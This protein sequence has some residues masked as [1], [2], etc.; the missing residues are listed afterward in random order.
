MFLLFSLS[1]I[2]VINSINISSTFEKAFNVDTTSPNC[3]YIESLPIEIDG[4]ADFAIQASSNGWPGS[5]IAGDPY[6]IENLN[7]TSTSTAINLIDISNTKSYFIVN[8]SLLVGGDNGVQLYNV[9]NAKFDNNTIYSN[10]GSGY[11]IMASWDNS[12]YNNTIYD[13]DTGIYLINAHNNCIDNNTIY[14]NNNDG[15]LC[16]NLGSNTISRNIVHNNNL[17]GMRFRDASNNTISDNFIYSNLQNGIYFG[18]SNESKVFNNTIFENANG[19]EFA[20]SGSCEIIDNLIYDNMALGILLTN[21]G[22]TNIS[23]NTFYNQIWYALRIMSGINYNVSLNNFIDNNPGLPPQ[24]IVEVEAFNSDINYNYWND[25]IMPDENLDDIVDDPY[26]IYEDNSYDYYPRTK[27]YIYGKVHIL[28]KPQMY[29]PNNGVISG[30]TKV[31]WG[32]ASDTMGHN[33]EYTL[34]F[35]TNGENWNLIADNILNNSYDWDTTILPDNYTYTIKVVAN[36]SEGFIQEDI[37]DNIFVIGNSLHTISVPEIL[38]PLGGTIIEFPILVEW[39]PSTDSWG[40]PV[41]Y[42]VFWSDDGGLQWDIIIENIA[43]TQCYWE[44]NAD[45]DGT[46]LIKVVVNSLG[47]IS[48]EDIS[49]PIII[50]DQGIGIGIGFGPY[51]IFSLIIIITL[52]FRVKRRKIDFKN[53]N[54]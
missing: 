23:R 27:A 18:A 48:N 24:A 14:G 29:Y 52:I 26:T 25:W 34:Y 22:K 3:S 7:I 36:C 13:S 2:L 38:Q 42:S 10:A 49:E 51:C 39:T 1:I 6:V 41:N 19:M 11:L 54:H 30:I 12:V 28:T 44:I 16:D 31:K 9:T 43:E 37:S 45:W 40:F 46:Y 50:P 35:S 33:V 47:G 21:S 53:F 15:L 8:D 17:N 32:I 4:D 20:V 5:G